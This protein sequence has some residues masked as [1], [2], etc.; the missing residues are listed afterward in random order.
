MVLIPPSRR[1]PTHPSNKGTFAIYF[2]DDVKKKSFLLKK[3]M[4]AIG[5]KREVYSG[6][7][8]HTSGGLTK[9]HLM[10]NKHGKIVSKKQHAAGKRLQK[11]YPLS[12]AMKKKAYAHMMAR[13]K[14]K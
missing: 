3:N 1:N 4:K 6:T 14:K 9:A 8:K 10:K 5:S 7:A 12:D 2:V 13:R 11:K